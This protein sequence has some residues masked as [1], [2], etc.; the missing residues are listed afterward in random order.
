M[1]LLIF[2]DHAIVNVESETNS[3]H[4][5]YASPLDPSRNSYPE[6]VKTPPGGLDV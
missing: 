6:L 4:L 1:A 5:S 3:F 2:S